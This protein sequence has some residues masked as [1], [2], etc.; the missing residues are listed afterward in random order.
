[1]VWR[2][3]VMLK[4]CKPKEFILSN[5]EVD[6]PAV[7]KSLGMFKSLS[8]YL[9]MSCLSELCS[10]KADLIS[11]ELLSEDQEKPG[12][13]IFTFFWGISTGSSLIYSS[14]SLGDGPGLC[15][16]PTTQLS[17]SKILS[18]LS[19]SCLSQGDWLHY[20]LWVFGLVTPWVSITHL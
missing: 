16:M 14:V 13:L 11:E 18:E 9:A 12:V 15:K 4:D 3:C 2:P 1:M 5:L 10:C 6:W 17:G 7:V 20:A 8:W 19:W